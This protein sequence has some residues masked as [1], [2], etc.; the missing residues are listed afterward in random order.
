VEERALSS[1]APLAV[2]PAG[3]VPPR[4]GESSGETPLDGVEAWPVPAA[5]G[6]FL[7]PLELASPVYAAPDKQAE[8]IGYLRIGARVARS[9]QPVSLRDCKEGWYALRPLGFMCAGQDATLDLEHPL[10]RAIQ[11]EPDRTRPMPY[12]YALSRASAPNYMR[13]PTRDEQLESELRLDRHLRKW[14]QLT[15]DWDALDVGANDVPLAANGLA[16]GPIPRHA[17]PLGMSER[18][19]GSG[20]D[21]LPWWLE[22]G[23][24]IPNFAP[25][26]VPPRALFANRMQRHAGVALIGSFVAEEAAQKRRFALTTDGRL[27]PTDK[28]RAEAGSPFHGEDLRNVGLPVAFGWKAGASFWRLQ[29]GQPRAAERLL[30]RQFVSLTGT[31]R[32]YDGVRMVETRSGSWLRSE[33]VRVAAKPR[34]LPWYASQERRWIDVSIVNQVLVLWEGDRPVYATLV[35][36][37]KDGLGD[38]KTTL[39]TPLG[40]FRIQQKHVTTTMDSNA[41]DN[42]FELRDVPW[43]MYFSGGYALHGAYWHDDFGRMRSHGCIN[44]APIDARYVFEWSL[45]VVPEHWHGTYAS[46][47]VGQGTILRIGR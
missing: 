22:G 33:D 20:Q 3:T 15:E 26:H 42:E 28:L 5:S 44:L 43:V 11:K 40:L 41:A 32:F 27:L 10:A 13:V 23:R 35:S 21:L 6:P 2:G 1:V 45:P 19:G 39:S 47:S 31:V 38:P 17:R 8:K 18:Y 46:S 4:A 36:T 9:D 12:A 14:N 24:Q 30:Q 16:N 29:A 25:L 34:E 7:A 37:G